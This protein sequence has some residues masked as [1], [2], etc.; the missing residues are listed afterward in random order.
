MKRSQKGGHDG[1]PLVPRYNSKRILDLALSE[2]CKLWLYSTKTNVYSGHRIFCC[3]YGMLLTRMVSRVM[4]CITIREQIIPSMR[5]ERA[6]YTIETD[7]VP[8]TRIKIQGR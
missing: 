2:I 1:M 5:T 4:A 6:L 7:D 3:L 8:R